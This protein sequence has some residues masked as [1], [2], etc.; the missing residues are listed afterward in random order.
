MSSMKRLRENDVLNNMNNNFAKETNE[1]DEDAEMKKFIE[2]QLKLIKKPLMGAGGEEKN[3]NEKKIKR[4]D[5]ALFDV[6]EHLIT[7]QS[8]IKSEETLSEQMLSGIPEVD[9]GVDEKIRNIEETEKFK[10]KLLYGNNEKRKTDDD[11]IYASNNQ[12]NF[13][14]HKR[15]DDSLI[16][17][18][19][20]IKPKIK[21]IAKQTPEPLPVVVGDD[22][23]SKHELLQKGELSPAPHFSGFKID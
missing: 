17:P 7:N 2:E 13:V 11:L 16:N 15:F 6:P 8:K 3:L 9:L 19:R 23:S 5:D 20:M 22:P 10:Q 14:Q 21:A 18:D 1:R 4:P 12:S